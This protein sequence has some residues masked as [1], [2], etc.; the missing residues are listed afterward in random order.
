MNNQFF[1][2]S[3]T[4]AN[5]FLQNIVFV[6]DEAYEN[7]EDKEH[8]FNP[9]AMTKVFA[10]SQKICSIYNP[11]KETEIEDLIKICNKADIV[12]IDWKINLER[13][14][15]QQLD[16]EADEEDDFRGK[17]SLQILKGILSTGDLSL[18]LLVIYTG[19]TD[20]WQITDDIH[21]SLNLEYPGFQKG[22]FEVQKNNVKVCIIGKTSIQAKHTEEIQAR[23]KSYEDLPEFLLTEFTKMTSGLLSNAAIKGLTK[24]RRKAAELIT[25]FHPSIDPAF[26]SHKALLPNPEDAEEQFL[27][28]LGSEIKS[29]L[30]GSNTKDYLPKIDIKTY[31]EDT[32]DDKLYEFKI[33]QQESLETIEIPKEI[34]RSL[35][36]RFT[37]VGIENVFFKKDTPIKDRNL[38][39]ENC[40]QDLTNYY[41]S[42]VELAKE[43][44]KKL[45]LLTSIKSNYNSPIPPLLTQGSVVFKR[46]D[47]TYWLCIQ[48]KCDT[49]R[50][51]G[52]R[53]FLFLPLKMV[54][55]GERFDFLL[56]INSHYIY[57]RIT[58][59]I[60]KSQFF[61][62]KANANREIRGVLDNDK[63]VF[64]G[65]TNPPLEW[66]GELKSDFA[67]SIANQFASN[68]SRVGMD[69]SEWLRRSS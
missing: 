68:L 49:I 67:Q 46:S 15:A 29:I 58:Q 59:T 22:H 62:F 50:I 16:E 6:D 43:S 7:K 11:T 51:E 13:D 32:L 55:E 2:I 42:S 39:S 69:H 26:L 1:E 64:K 37:E 17:Y 9:F 30:K 19:E 66:I 10:K 14:S 27:D 45:A 54:N 28:I 21:Q 38:F 57:F 40:Y 34:A 44:N 61:T 53:D 20:L 41:T 65:N 33:P 52:N 36:V 47:N 25:A 18:K 35:L 12:V 63:I 23:I 48:P 60:Y 8:D 56:K 24:I 5:G 4:I 31:L 3:K